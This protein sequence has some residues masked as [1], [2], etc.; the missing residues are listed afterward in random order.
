M[1][2]F[3]PTIKDR[4][5]GGRVEFYGNCEECRKEHYDTDRKSVARKL[6]RCA[7]V[8]KKEK[9][10]AAADEVKAR[11][12]K[13]REQSEDKARREQEARQAEVNRVRKQRIKKARELRRD[14]KG[15]KCPFCGKQPC[16]GTRPKCAAVKA[17]EFESAFDIDV[18]DPATFD[19]QLRFYRDNM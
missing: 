18:S 19:Q 14:A 3:G 13:A 4:S 17:V 7:K 15:K 12:Q 1:G 2:W 6:E 9:E 16:A 11:A 5:R 10:K 8:D